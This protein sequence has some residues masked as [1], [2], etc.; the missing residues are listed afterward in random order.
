MKRDPHLKININNPWDVFHVLD[1]LAIECTSK[2]LSEQNRFWHKATD[3]SIHATKEIINA[4]LE[5]P[6]QPEN[7]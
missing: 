4:I 1:T 5:D 7:S 2:I 6:C 3:I